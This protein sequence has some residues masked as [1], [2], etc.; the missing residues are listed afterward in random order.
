MIDEV[1]VHYVRGAGSRS[2]CLH[3]CKALKACTVLHMHTLPDGKDLQH[4][5]LLP[6]LSSAAIHNGRQGDDDDDDD[7]REPVPTRGY[8]NA[9]Y[10]MH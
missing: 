2:H 3:C 10:H 6:T 5:A 1:D 7:V 4:Q 9:W 8:L